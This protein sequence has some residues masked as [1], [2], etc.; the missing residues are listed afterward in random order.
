MAQ[1]IVARGDGQIVKTVKM[2]AALI[3]TMAF[4]AILMGY[5]AL[6]APNSH[7][8]RRGTPPA[9][10]PVRE[11]ELNPATGAVIWSSVALPTQVVL[12]PATGSTV[13]SPGAAAP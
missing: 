11:V 2:R 8:M 1:E 3:G 9:V 10:L 6:L 7:P 4:A 13:P 5:G 12:D